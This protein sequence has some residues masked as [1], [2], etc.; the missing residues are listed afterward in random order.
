MASGVGFGFG[1][2]A[3]RMIFGLV[4]LGIIVGGLYLYKKTKKANPAY[5]MP[6]NQQVKEQ[7]Q[8]MYGLP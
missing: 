3:G 4:M 7:Q 6:F 8:Y 2:A 1:F 5:Y